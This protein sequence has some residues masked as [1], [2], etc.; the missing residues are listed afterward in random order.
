MADT[1]ETSPAKIE[2]LGIADL[3]NSE[4]NPNRDLTKTATS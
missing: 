3:E 2:T 4:G 1:V